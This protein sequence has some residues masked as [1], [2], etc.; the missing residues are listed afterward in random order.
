MSICA[1]AQL[2]VRL[3]SLIPHKLSIILL[4]SS[5][6]MLSVTKKVLLTFSTFL[7]LNSH[8]PSATQM[9][10]SVSEKRSNVQ[11]SFWEDCFLMSV[12]QSQAY[13]G[14]AYQLLRCHFVRSFTNFGFPKLTTEN[15]QSFLQ[16]LEFFL[17]NKEY[18]SKLW[19]ET[20]G[21]F[22]SERSLRSYFSIIIHT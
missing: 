20:N 8:V 13:L 14:K 19:L 16:L 2:A 22:P 9:K 4:R 21:V 15:N 3:R 18:T 7:R 17:Q 1:Y 10:G 11:L 6:D 12:A 5:V